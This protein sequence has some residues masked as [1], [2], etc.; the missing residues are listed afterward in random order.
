MVN[1]SKQTVGNG[2]M[3]CRDSDAGHILDIDILRMHYSLYVMSIMPPCSADLFALHTRILSVPGNILK[4]SRSTCG[5][6]FFMAKM[7]KALQ[8]GVWS[9][10]VS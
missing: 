4:L 2:W 7:G 6:S 10:G 3:P 9:Y 1:G 5:T 8:Y